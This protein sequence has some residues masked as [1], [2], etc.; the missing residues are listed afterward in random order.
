MYRARPRGEGKANAADKPLRKVFGPTNLDHFAA[1]REDITVE[2]L[3]EKV[4]KFVVTDGEASDDID[5]LYNLDSFMEVRAWRRPTQR[6]SAI[7]TLFLPPPWLVCFFFCF[8]PVLSSPL[9][10]HHALGKSREP[11]KEFGPSICL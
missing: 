1:T 6:K 4:K 3:I 9:V 10:T 2:I 11:A 7:H 5:N 8:I